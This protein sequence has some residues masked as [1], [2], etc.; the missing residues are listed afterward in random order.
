VEACHPRFHEF[1][2]RKRA[3]D[4]DEIFSSDWYVHHEA[5]LADG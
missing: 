5:L 2:A 3:H 1:L 4:P